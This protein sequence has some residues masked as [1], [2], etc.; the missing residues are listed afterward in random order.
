MDQGRALSAGESSS[1]RDDVC[2]HVDRHR[3]ALLLAAHGQGVISSTIQSW[4]RSS[5]TRCARSMNDSMSRPAR[6]SIDFRLRRLSLWS[7]TTAAVRWSIGR[8]SSTVTWRSLAS[9]ITTRKPPPALREIRQE[10]PARRFLRRCGALS[11]RVRKAASLCSFPKSGRR[12][13]WLIHPLRASTGA[14]P[15]LTAARCSLRLRASG[16]ILKG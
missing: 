12:A 6:S 14:G 11:V 15:R 7:P 4:R 9:C 16:S 5:V 8:F 1:G 10:A 13:K 2:L 3:P